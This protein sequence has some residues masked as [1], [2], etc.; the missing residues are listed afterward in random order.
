[1]AAG[2]VLRARPGVPADG[3][4]LSEALEADLGLEACDCVL[5]EPALGAAQP[6]L[7]ARASHAPGAAPLDRDVLVAG[8]AGRESN[9]ARVRAVAAVDVQ[10][11]RR[12]RLVPLAPVSRS[13]LP[14]AVEARL[15]LS[16][17]AGARDRHPWNASCHCGNALVRDG[18]VVELDLPLHG[19]LVAVPFALA[20]QPHAY[21]RLYADARGLDA[22][23]RAWGHISAATLIDVHAGSGERWHELEADWPAPPTASRVVAR[24]SLVRTGGREAERLGVLMRAA[25]GSADAQWHATLPPPRSLLLS[26]PAGVGK[27][28]LVREIASHLGALVCTIDADALCC[29]EPADALRDAAVLSRDERVVV[30]VDG[31]PI[32]APVDADASRASDELARLATFVAVLRALEGEGEGADG[33]Y[34][35]GLVVVGVCLDP[36]TLHADVRACWADHVRLEPPSAEERLAILRECLDDLDVCLLGDEQR[37]AAE[38]RG[39]AL[40]GGAGARAFAASAELLAF[41]RGL[42]GYVAADIRALAAEARARALEEQH[43]AR[44]QGGAPVSVRVRVHE[45]ERAARRVPPSS[46]RDVSGAR[47]FVPRVA[48][49]DVCGLDGAKAQLEELLVWPHE[50]GELLDELGVQ[51]AQGVLLYGPPGT[52]KTLLAQAMASHSRLNFMSV[53]IPEL[54]KGDVGGSEEAIAA[55]F[56]KAKEFAPTLLFLDEL[57][58]F[59]GAPHDRAGRARGAERPPRGAV[60]TSLAQLLLEMDACRSGAAFERV[61]VVGATNVPDAL[62]RSL[63]QPGRFEH[64]LLVRPPDCDARAHILARALRDLPLAAHSATLDAVGGGWAATD[65]PAELAALT[66]GFSAA[67]LKSLCHS[68]VY[69]AIDEGASSLTEAH[70]RHALS[71][72]E[73]SIDASMMARLQE[74]ETSFFRGISRADGVDAESGGS[75]ASE[76]DEEG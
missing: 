53:Q 17:L 37:T 54:V 51:M 74:W 38:R 30:L 16:R 47:P 68:A 33:E 13:A 5:I 15:R 44:E 39:G 64:V 28:T 26:G 22:E 63:L 60:H 8:E 70:L 55:V 6:A 58:A 69:H 18:A 32:L 49:G 42:H 2:L 62:D 65:V 9:G 40:A 34:G 27:R 57:Q 14:S 21:S 7:L 19:G 3:C 75:G 10:E 50:H 1:M 29:G 71:R 61:V 36:G 72:F 59:F 35:A 31:L 43:A 76:E 25:L 20:A 67:D 66:D 73:P 46:L 23:T 11:W 41:A 56:A 45:L 12:V 24:A 4:A 52:G 48:W